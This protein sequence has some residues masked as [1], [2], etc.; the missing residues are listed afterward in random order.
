M[1]DRTCNRC[2]QRLSPQQKKFC[3]HACANITNTKARAARNAAAARKS[4]DVPGCGKP[5]RSRTAELCPMHYHRLYRYGSLERVYPAGKSTDF[6]NPRKMDDLTGRRFGTLTVNA[7]EAGRW[8][9]RCDCGERRLARTGDL[10]RYGDSNTCGRKENHLDPIV[11]YS[12]A[13]DRVRRVRGSVQ[14]YACIDC[15]SIGQHWS[16]D[17]GDPDELLAYGL[18]ANAIPYSTKPEHYVPRCVSCHKRHDLAKI[19]GTL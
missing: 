13:H 18:S 5:A 11:G 12:G 10:R 1:H 16:Y 14:Q 6:I 7:R 15:G 19:S 17:H 9:C 2:N 8:L 4:C 3:S